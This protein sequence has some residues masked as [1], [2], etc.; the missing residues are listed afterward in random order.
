MQKSVYQQKAMC[1]AAINQSHLVANGVVSGVKDNDFELLDSRD[2]TYGSD[3]VTYQHLKNEV[4]DSYDIKGF[5]SGFFRYTKDDNPSPNRQKL[6]HLQLKAMSEVINMFSDKHVVYMEGK[7]T[8]YR[9]QQEAMNEATDIGGYR[10]HIKVQSIEYRLIKYNDVAINID[11]I[12]NRTPL[13]VEFI[14][15]TC[16]GY[17]MPQMGCGITVVV[18]GVDNTQSMTGVMLL[19]AFDVASLASDYYRENKALNT[20]YHPL[21]DFLKNCSDVSNYNLFIKEEDGNFG[22]VVINNQFDING[23]AMPEKVFGGF[24]SVDNACGWLDQTKPRRLYDEFGFF[25]GDFENR[26]NAY[27]DHQANVV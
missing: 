12:F 16:G 26:L 3:S 5:V 8:A 4:S 15:Q 20:T 1:I 10:Y 25:R 24:T 17:F 22:V 7:G 27:P 21:P 23:D 2:N 14:V 13:K 9:T 6:R 11:M 19:A 18:D